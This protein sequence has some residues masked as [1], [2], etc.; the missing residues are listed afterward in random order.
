MAFN[1]LETVREN[2]K[3]V[4]S[5]AAM[6]AMFVF[7][8]TFGQG[9][10]LNTLGGNSG[11]DKGPLAANLYGK[12]VFKGDVLQVRENYQMAEILRFAYNNQLNAN[13]RRESEAKRPRF[14]ATPPQTLDDLLDQ[15]IWSAQADKL[16]IRLDEE[17]MRRLFN[18]E[19]AT[20]S[21]KDPWPEGQAF[22]SLPFVATATTIAAMNT[23]RPVTALAMKDALRGLMSNMLAREVVLGQA[24]GGMFQMMMGG[25]AGAVPAT[26]LAPTPEEFQRFYYRNLTRVAAVVQP[27]PLPPV[28][29]E[30]SAQDVSDKEIQEF[31]DRYKDVEPVPG[32]PFPGFKSAQLYKLTWVA[33]REDSVQVK[34]QVHLL[35]VVRVLAPIQAL[36]QALAGGAGFTA[37]YP[38]SDCSSTGLPVLNEDSLPGLAPWLWLDPQL[39]AFERRDLAIKI[40]PFEQRRHDGAHQKS[41]ALLEKLTPELVTALVGLG[42]SSTNGSGLAFA[43]AGPDALA[44]FRRVHRA[45]ASALLA[46]GTGHMPYAALGITNSPGKL[47]AEE[48]V[49]ALIAPELFLASRKAAFDRQVTSFSEYISSLRGAGGI[50][51]KDPAATEAKVKERAQALG[52]SYHP[53]AAPADVV[54]VEKDPVVQPLVQAY[55]ESLKA[56]S[57]GREVDRPFADYLRSQVRGVYLASRISLKNPAV[58]FGMPIE[59]QKESLPEYLF[60]ASDEQASRPR[61][62][63]EV[64]PLVKSEILLRRQIREV[65][66]KAKEYQEF[67]KVCTGGKPIDMISGEQCMAKLREKFPELKG[68]L[69]AQVFDGKSNLSRAQSFSPAMSGSYEQSRIPI[70]IIRYPRPESLLLLADTDPGSALVLANNPGDSLYLALVTSK[71]P[72]SESEFKAAYQG[73]SKQRELNE[74]DTLYQ[75][76]TQ[77]TNMRY[78]DLLMQDLRRE[79]SGADLD[80][81]GQITLKDESLRRNVD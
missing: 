26:T 16:G 21:M 51:P 40:A 71:V 12:P 50:P 41:G 7:V 65:R 55:Q 9:D 52:F 70:N 20:P 3:I 75:R 13:Q 38:W 60:W 53:M 74:P 58:S 36:G 46:A 67:L 19:L 77:A 31:F 69:Q 39:G 30:S 79:A 10:I 29:A 22:E 1:P 73:A 49:A 27:L 48:T 15:L 59:P 80:S 45:A 33:A 44:R 61:S 32:S 6:V 57:P 4:M 81:Q 76:F 54:G 14:L 47:A 42:A 24:A 11:A 28:G 5:V 78:E 72:P 25:A 43:L 68:M 2:S 8:L 35:Q 37:L 18:T 17:A 34:S 23:R 66:R 62:L 56:N 64:R 63:D